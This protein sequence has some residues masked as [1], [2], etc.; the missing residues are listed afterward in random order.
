MTNSNNFVI[1]FIGGTKKNEDE[2]SGSSTESSSSSGSGSS[3]AS[4][5]GSSSS[6]SS[7]SSSGSRSPLRARS[8]SSSKLRSISGPSGV[9]PDE[10]KEALANLS[11]NDDDDGVDRNNNDDKEDGVEAG[12]GLGIDQKEKIEE[13]SGFDVQ[14][15]MLPLSDDAEV[16]FLLFLSLMIKYLSIE[17]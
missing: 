7:S 10:L 2:S 12:S 9:D 4:S 6:S 13:F 11:K 3:S 15:N 17:N 1:I 8:S 5:S 14:T 16:I